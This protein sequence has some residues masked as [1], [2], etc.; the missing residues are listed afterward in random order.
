MEQVHH[1]PII[2]A[3]KLTWFTKGLRPLPG[4]SGSEIPCTEKKLTWFTKGLRR[5]HHSLVR[6]YIHCKE[7]DLIYEGIAT[8]LHRTLLTLTE[9]V[10]RNWPDLRRDCDVLVGSDL[11]KRVF[12]ETD[13]IYEGI[14]TIRVSA[15]ISVTSLKETDLIYEG[16]ATTLPS[17]IIEATR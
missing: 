17:C 6:Q 9:R 4:D 7:T 3:K 12:K 11:R 15:F 14:A 16:I 13:L 8:F 2:I 10:E 1:D 5:D